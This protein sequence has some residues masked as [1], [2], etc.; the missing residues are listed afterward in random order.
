MGPS[1][2]AAA[3]AAAS[4]AAPCTRLAMLGFMGMILTEAIS[5]LNT[6]QAWGLQP[7]HFTGFH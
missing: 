3:V 6:L 1:A 7:T 5:G 2:A 4:P